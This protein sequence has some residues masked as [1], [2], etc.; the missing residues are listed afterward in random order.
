MDEKCKDKHIHTWMNTAFQFEC[1]AHTLTIRLYP[2][3]GAGLNHEGWS[4][5]LAPLSKEKRTSLTRPSDQLRFSLYQNL[6]R[7]ILLRTVHT[8]TQSLP[9]Q[10]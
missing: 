8:Q 2:K 9:T 7:H 5:S 4:A 3:T 1:C 6:L 10:S